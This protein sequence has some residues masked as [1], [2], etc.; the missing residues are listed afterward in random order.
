MSD[1]RPAPDQRLVVVAMHNESIERA[2]HTHRDLEFNRAAA[3]PA[4]FNIRLRAGRRIDGGGKHFTAVW[5]LN[6]CINEHV[7]SGTYA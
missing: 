1:S 7:I 6:F 3:N 2:V 4:V 5:A